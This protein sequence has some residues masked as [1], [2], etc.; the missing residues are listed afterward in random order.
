MLAAPSLT[1]DD[2]IEIER[3]LASRSF[4]EYRKLIRPKMI[5]GWW[6]RDCAERLQRFYE[7]LIAG[8]RPKMLIEAPPQHGKTE[9]IIDFVSWLAGKHPGLKTIYTSF[10]ERLGV[11]ANLSLQRLYDR[12]AYKRI[13]PDTR[14]DTGS[15][16]QRTREIL[17]YVGTE[18]YFRNTTVLGP[19]TGEGLDLGIIDDPIKGREAAGSLAIRNKTWDWLTDDFFS[20][21][22]ESAGL[23]SIM[24]RWHV[25]DP[26]GRMA[27]QMEGV[28]CVRY[29]A[30]ATQDETYRK[31]GDPL[32]PELKSLEFLEERR[33]VMMTV[34][35]SALYQ[36][37]PYVEG[38]GLFKIE[39]F[40]IVGA[41][42]KVKRWV[43]YWDKA[44][45][46]GGGAH[47]AGVL[48]GLLEDGRVIVADVERGQW[49]A[50]NREKRIK[51]TADIDGLA[52]EIWIEQEPGSGGKES[53]ENSIRGL[54]GYKVHLD[55]VTGS[56]EDRAES[57]AA[58]VEAGNV[59]LLAGDWN[60][61]FI[62]EHET[63]PDGAF[64]DQVDAASGAFNK[65]FRKRAKA[66]V[67]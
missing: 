42:P 61:E 18:G 27:D 34:R 65:L 25:D 31:K 12:E 48:M 21:F 62:D 36:Q 40:Q 8:E 67:W 13:F 56:K 2:W 14:L 22:S 10:S 51:L 16:H 49:T 6:Q 23:L 3:E 29:E 35:W 41:V 53:A 17:E 64:K 66:G 24:T 39:G 60:K 33:H 30:I 19:I 63:F 58:Q 28:E 20:R 50:M 4:A 1:E 59:L 5:D 55:R 26:H 38:G 11:R 57:Y 15:T 47:T 9:L 7:R 43:R 46:E 54:S 32:F 52:T 44:G 37:S 45:T